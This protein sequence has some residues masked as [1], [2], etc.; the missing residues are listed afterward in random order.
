MYATVVSYLRKKCRICLE[1]K[2]Q[3]K[4]A[5][6]ISVFLLIFFKSTTKYQTHSAN[7]FA[8]AFSYPLK[9]SDLNANIWYEVPE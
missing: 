4:T 6:K 5:L 3:Y 9:H 8:Q 7:L 2:Q 1:R